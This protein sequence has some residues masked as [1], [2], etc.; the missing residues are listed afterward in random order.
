M[1]YLQQ[2]RQIKLQ[3][4]DWSQKPNV[5]NEKYKL[6]CDKV[7]RVRLPPPALDSPLA[8]WKSGLGARRSHQC[9]SA[10][11]AVP[12]TPHSGHRRDA[13]H[14]SPALNPPGPAAAPVSLVQNTTHTH[15][16]AANDPPSSSQTTQRG[17]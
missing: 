2:L 10:L 14:S 13:P 15:G 7:T 6:E 16:P 17:Y 11:S 3:E 4:L 12:H 8:I 1:V 5:K 9:R